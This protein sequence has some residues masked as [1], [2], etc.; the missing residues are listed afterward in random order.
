MKYSIFGESH[1][2]AIGVV[3][4]GVPAGLELDMAAIQKQ[5]DRRKP[6]N[7]PLSTARREADVPKILSGVFQG[8]TT[9][10]PLC[11]VMEN[12]D[13]HSGDYEATKDLARPGHAD[14]PAHVRYE[15]FRDY[16]GGGHFSGRLTAPLCIAGGLCKQWLAQMGIEIRGHIVSIAGIS[17]SPAHLD[18]VQPDLQALNIHFPV[19]SSDARDAMTFKILRAK[20]MGDSV[21]GEVEC[22]ITGLPAGIGEPMFG[23]IE[24]KIAQ[25]VYGIP[26]VKAVEFGLGSAM[27]QFR[28]SMVNDAFTVEDGKVKTATNYCGGI[29][30]GIST[31]MP[32]VFKASVKPTPSIA[33]RQQSVDLKNSEVTALEIQG[34]HDPCIV[35]RAVPVLEAAAAIAIYDLILGNTQTERRK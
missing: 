14:W 2:P 15:G 16:R 35:P 33:K 12:T 20:D 19:F 3:L 32:I 22:F 31:G 13:A 26:A 23:G 18:F 10:A 5:L 9:G 24:S 30:G 11:A 21:G 34:R 17:D 4:E 27:A 25:I 28:G 7:N 29:L 6:G 1:G 8:K